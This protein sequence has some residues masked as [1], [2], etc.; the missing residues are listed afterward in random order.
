MVLADGSAVSTRVL[1]VGGTGLDAFAGVGGPYMRDGVVVHDDAIGLNLSGVEFGLALFSAK[2]GQP[3][4]AGL[5]WTA[6]RARAAEV[7]LVGVQDV[8]MAVRDID[9]A[10]NLVAGVPTAFDADLK[11]IDFSSAALPV[12]T[13]TGRSLA[14]QMDGDQGRLVR[15][16]ADVSLGVADFFQL[17]GSIG[18]ERSTTSQ[19]PTNS[20][21]ARSTPTHGASASATSSS[22]W[23]CSRPSPGR[24]T[25]RTARWT[26]SPGLL[27]KPVWGGWT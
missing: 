16:S 5:S 25:R 7:S 1:S 19:G 12:P 24:R 20:P 11:V 10:I 17:E 21:R 22:V 13:G 2:S 26:D 3:A 6:L 15:A 18:F 27:C 4:A 23:R 9:V 14:L 8:T